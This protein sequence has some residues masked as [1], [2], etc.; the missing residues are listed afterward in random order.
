MA[1]SHRTVVHWLLI[2]GLSLGLFLLFTLGAAWVTRFTDAPEL[3]EPA[4]PPP[5]LPPRATAPVPAEP[6][7]LPA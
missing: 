5:A 1:S 7:R 6:S 3:P 4:A 2:P